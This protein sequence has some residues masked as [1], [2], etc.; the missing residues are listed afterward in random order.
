MP[1]LAVPADGLPL[2]AGPRQQDVA[3]RQLPGVSRAVWLHHHL[4][5]AAFGGLRA[6]AVFPAAQPPGRIFSR[7]FG[8]GDCS[9]F[10]PLGAGGLFAPLLPGRL[11]C[12]CHQPVGGRG[13]VP[14]A[15][16]VFPGGGCR[17]LAVAVDVPPLPAGKAC[18][19]C[20]AVLAHRRE[21]PVPGECV[22]GGSRPQRFFL[23]LAVFPGRPDR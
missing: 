23:A 19:C 12:L 3:W 4:A 9:P 14:L 20:P 15:A 22:P 17:L 13:F 8:G 5:G 7:S 1:V 21:L 18:V 10:S 2:S 6:P 16:V 11:G